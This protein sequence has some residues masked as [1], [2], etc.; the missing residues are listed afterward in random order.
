[1][2][3]SLFTR[4]TRALSRKHLSE[5]PPVVSDWQ[6][7][8]QQPRCPHYCRG[9]CCNSGRRGGFAPCPFDGKELLL[10]DASHGDDMLDPSSLLGKEVRTWSLPF[11][12]ATESIS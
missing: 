10:E 12:W 11:P 6:Q 8:C 2:T 3:T 5:L 7:S 1:M 9:E 4:D